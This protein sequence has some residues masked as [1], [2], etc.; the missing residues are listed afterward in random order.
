M[1]NVLTNYLNK[2]MVED[3]PS[4]KRNWQEA[5]PVIT[6]SREVGCNGLKLAHKLAE[7][8]NRK[9]RTEKWKVLSKEVF[10][11]SAEELN[12][13]P[14]NVRR[15]FKQ[16]SKYVFEDILKAFNNKNYK[17][18][19]KIANTVSEAVLSFAIDGYCIIVGRAA[20]IIASEIENALHLRLT[21]PLEYRVKN[22]QINNSLNHE[23]AVRF[24]AKVE[25]ERKAFRKAI[26]E[27]NLREELFDLTLNRSSFGTDELVE[28]IEI[29]M[30][31]KGMITKTKSNL[32]YY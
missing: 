6:M 16:S 32:Q 20:H 19:R 4:K 30:A 22:I 15:V 28:M 3:S 8:L 5:G 7:S 23:E 1:S 31:K 18:D 21:A 17:S 12:M 27:E 25:K 14:E 13:E 29:A 2:R 11:Q 24:I 10:H 9:K 26:R